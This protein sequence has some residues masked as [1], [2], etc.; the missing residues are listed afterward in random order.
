MAHLQAQKIGQETD[1]QQRIEA[2]LERAGYSR[3][4]FGTIV[5]TL[6]SCGDTDEAVAAVE[7]GPA[8][9]LSLMECLA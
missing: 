2:A 9:I 6:T 8:S 7:S 5:E 1:T 4:L 3:F